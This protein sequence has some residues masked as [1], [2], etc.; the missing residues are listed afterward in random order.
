MTEEG[1]NPNPNLI[2]GNQSELM[3]L[4]FYFTHVP[5]TN[6]CNY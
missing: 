3:G 5:V 6:D 1:D 4:Q 2:L